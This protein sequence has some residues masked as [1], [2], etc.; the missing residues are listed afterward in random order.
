MAYLQSAPLTSHEMQVENDRPQLVWLQ[1]KGFLPS[2]ILN[3]GIYS[4]FCDPNAAASRG[5]C[6]GQRG[7][8]EEAG[9]GSAPLIDGSHQWR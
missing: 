3:I 7:K 6:W 2:F 5:P 4:E 1:F 8:G 9:G